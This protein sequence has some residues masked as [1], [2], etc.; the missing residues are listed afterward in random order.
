MTKL[1]RVI[2]YVL[3]IN[4]NA[5]SKADVTD[6]LTTNKY[7]EFIT[8]GEVLETDVGV[9][10]DDHHLNKTDTDSAQFDSYFAELDATENDP[11]FKQE[12]RR[13]RSIMLQQIQKNSTLEQ[14]LRTLKEEMKKLENVRQFVKTMKEL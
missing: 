8:I 1:Y 10:S 11:W 7:P 6:Q 4:G 3:D 2:A 13:V 14:E 12:H 9:W 5:P